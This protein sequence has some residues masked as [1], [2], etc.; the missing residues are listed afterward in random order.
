MVIESQS[1]SIEVMKIVASAVQAYFETLHC[2]A[3]REGK[4]SGDIV[5]FNG[6]EKLKVYH[7]DDR[8][9]IQSLKKDPHAANKETGTNH[10][11]KILEYGIEHGF[12]EFVQFKNWFDGLKKKDDAAD[13]FLHAMR[14]VIMKHITREELVEHK[15]YL[16][17]HKRM[18]YELFQDK[19]GGLG[20]STAGLKTNISIQYETD[21]DDEDDVKMVATSK[22]KSKKEND[23]IEK[24]K[25]IED[26][27]Q[28][29]DEKI[30]MASSKG[31]NKRVNKAPSHYQA[32]NI[33]RPV[34]PKC[35]STRKFLR[36]VDVDQIKKA[37]PLKS[38]RGFDELFENVEIRKN[39]IDVEL[40]DSE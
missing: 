28:I 14:Y 23:V 29:L 25:S 31:K 27:E 40:S 12:E 32:L 3:R 35:K 15:K 10:C 2:Q 5:Y 18:F 36:D 13:S 37:K 17:E 33:E 22:K 21:D 4:I 38:L 8:C 20:N 39:Y 24:S 7:G 6:S 16:K 9:K 34:A 30:K 11:V 26:D 1:Q 19:Y